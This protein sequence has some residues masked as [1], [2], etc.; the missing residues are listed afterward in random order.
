M[1]SV[2]FRTLLV[3]VSMRASLRIDKY[4]KKLLITKPYTTFVTVDHQYQ[5]MQQP[6]TLDINIEPN[7]H[8]KKP[9]AIQRLSDIPLNITAP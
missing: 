5:T 7:E 3:L 9:T 2:G 6:Q 1:V 4:L 8:P